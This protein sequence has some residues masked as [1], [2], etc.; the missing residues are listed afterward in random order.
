MNRLIAYLAAVTVFRQDGSKY[1]MTDDLERCKNGNEESCSQIRNYLQRME[2]QEL[3]DI[4][5]IKCA[6]INEAVVYVEKDVGKLFDD[7]M[8]PCHNLVDFNERRL[9]KPSSGFAFANKWVQDGNLEKL[10][11]EKFQSFSDELE[12][13]SQIV[14]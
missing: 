4:R 2:Q 14:K 9:Y 8:H 13:L 11:V 7:E 12:K 5:N 3:F 1:P 10:N 6:M